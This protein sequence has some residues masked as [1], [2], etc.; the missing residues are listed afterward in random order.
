MRF[1]LIKERNRLVTKFCNCLRMPNE[2]WKC[3]YPL[4]DICACMI[5]DPGEAMERTQV[6]KGIFNELAT[7]ARLKPNKMLWAEYCT[8]IKNQAA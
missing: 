1:E 4:K 2:T 8:S 7:F 5:N 3:I 6:I